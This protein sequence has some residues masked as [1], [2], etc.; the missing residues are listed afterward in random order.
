LLNTIHLYTVRNYA[1]SILL[2]QRLRIPQPTFFSTCSFPEAWREVLALLTARTGTSH[3]GGGRERRE[4]GDPEA[5][6]RIN[7]VISWNWSR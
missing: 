4:K 7:D 6:G 3:V 1:V 2:K 5:N